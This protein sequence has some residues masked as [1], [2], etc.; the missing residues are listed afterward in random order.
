MDTVV[1]VQ[2]LHPTH[3]ALTVFVTVES[4]VHVSGYAT[5]DVVRGQAKRA[6]RQL[7]CTHDSGVGV[8][9]MVLV[10]VGQVAQAVGMAVIT[11]FGTA[12]AAEKGLEMI[13]AV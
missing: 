11:S 7:K 4:L 10:T 6:R 13:L 5:V 12:T 3:D 8:T 9:V 1:T 2:P